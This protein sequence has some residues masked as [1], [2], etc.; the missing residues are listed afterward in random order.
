VAER[1]WFARQFELEAVRADPRIGGL[2]RASIT[3]P[4]GASDAAA[5]IA[6]AFADDPEDAFPG[7]MVGEARGSQARPS[8]A[9]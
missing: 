6:K 7:G 1:W 5:P 4:E 2:V 9:S 3:K 8:A